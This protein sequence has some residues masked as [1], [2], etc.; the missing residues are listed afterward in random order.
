MPKNDKSP[1]QWKERFCRSMY[2]DFSL[3]PV[4]HTFIHLAPA[5]QANDL[6]REAIRF[7][8]N[9]TNHPAG[10]P[11]KQRESL[12][13]GLARVADRL[14]KGT[15]S[16]TPSSGVEDI[17]SSMPPETSSTAPIVDAVPAAPA[18]SQAKSS[19]E[20]RAPHVDTLP[21][22]APGEPTILMPES[23]ISTLGVAAATPDSL[24]TSALSVVESMPAAT[25]APD[26]TR[27]KWSDRMLNMTPTTTVR[28]GAA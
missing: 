25:P 3:D 9:A 6:V 14:V 28:G 15:A 5:G 27:K 22:K 23:V 26:V 1:L 20:T 13:N 17:T 24:Q 4:S 11:E 10:N 2:F 12:M 21:A 19:H 16:L 7:Y 18:I 8:V